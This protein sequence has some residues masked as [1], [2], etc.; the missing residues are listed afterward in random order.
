VKQWW[1]R[2]IVSSGGGRLQF[3]HVGS[4]EL[5]RSRLRPLGG[6]TRAGKV[7]D[8]RSLRG[9]KP[10]SPR[11]GVVVA[12]TPLG[13]SALPR[14]GGGDEE[15]EEGRNEGWGKMQGVME[16]NR[17]AE[18]ESGVEGSREDATG[19]REEVAEN[20]GAVVFMR[21]E[22]RSRESAPGR[23]WNGMSLVAPLNSIEA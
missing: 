14:H 8:E 1:R 11:E 15:V 10:V 16:G 9:G 19:S 5:E 17:G 12:S 4:I 7:G 21:V 22:E 20:N 2:G 13:L 23:E 18:M 3:D 6:V